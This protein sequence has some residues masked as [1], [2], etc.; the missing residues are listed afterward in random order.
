MAT[1]AEN[2]TVLERKLALARDERQGDTRSILRALRLALARAADE[3]VGLAMSVIGATQAR[4]E[5]D[6]LGRAVAEDRLYLMLS[7]PEGALGAACMDRA[8]VTA[9]LQQQTMGQVVAGGFVERAF[10]GTDAAMVAPLI[11]A[12]LPRARD[13]VD[14]PLDRVCLT[15]YEFCA[16]AESRRAL[17]LL[18][19]YDRYRVFDLTAEIAGGKAQG[20]ITLIL[21]DRP[22]AALEGAEGAAA[23][24]GLHLDAAFG[25]V[26]ADLDAVISR[27]RLPLAAFAGMQ[28]G[29]LLPL[30]GLK[31]DRTEIVTIEGRQVALARLGQCRGMRA[32]R[33]NEKL[34]DPERIEQG[35]DG[36]LAHKPGE[37]Q[38][39]ETP[40]DPDVIDHE[41]RPPARPRHRAEDYEDVDTEAE[42]D[43]DA[44]SE[45]DLPALSTDQ[46]ATEIAE[47]AG[48]PREEETAESN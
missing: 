17:L 3:A 20:Q 38:R 27:I 24:Q 22:E 16:R 42:G 8:C 11:D 46:V 6:E 4:R 7:G 12:L 14:Q 37:G 21:P 43:L 44:L 5:L 33:L 40:P 23:P 1:D 48:L 45:Y 41:A 34:P 29:D 30:V 36:F 47:L 9:I 26:R 18:L 35:P 32:V 13:M 39:P 25:V 28:P 31:L 10:T 19:E 2:K 15:G